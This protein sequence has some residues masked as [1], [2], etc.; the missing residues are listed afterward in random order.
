M[1]WNYQRTGTQVYQVTIEMGELPMSL[2]GKSL[3]QRMFRIDDT[4]SNYWGDPARANLQQIS[5][6]T[7]EP[8]K[9]HSVTVDLSANALQLVVLEL[10][11]SLVK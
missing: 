11:S 5:E 10:D 2:R 7:I 6:T 8:G 1:V 4:T 3:R 9:Q